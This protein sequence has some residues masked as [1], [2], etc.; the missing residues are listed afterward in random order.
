MNKCCCVLESGINSVLEGVKN[1]VGC[2][3]GVV[4]WQEIMAMAAG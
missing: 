3:I 1:P 2:G 4:T